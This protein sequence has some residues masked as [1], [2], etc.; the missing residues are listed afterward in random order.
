MTSELTFTW[1]GRPVTA[2]LDDELRWDSSEPQAVSMLTELCPPATRCTK[3]VD[4]RRHLLYVAA[5]RLGG[6]VRTR[7]TPAA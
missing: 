3:G 6:E 4:G 7:A 1:Q 2:R 5:Q